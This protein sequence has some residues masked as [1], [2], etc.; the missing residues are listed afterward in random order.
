MTINKP[1]KGTNISSV[2]VSEQHTKKNE[3]HPPAQMMQHLHDHHSVVVVA[4]VG[5]P[6]CPQKDISTMINTFAIS[7]WTTHFYTLYG[8]RNIPTTTHMRWKK[9]LQTSALPFFSLVL[10]NTTHTHTLTKRLISSNSCE[11]RFE[12]KS[13]S[14]V[15]TSKTARRDRILPHFHLP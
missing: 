5:A 2:C 14:P 15:K 12:S 8:F 13:K 10:S 9:K 7:N 1:Y 4:V 3:K 11:R 6:R